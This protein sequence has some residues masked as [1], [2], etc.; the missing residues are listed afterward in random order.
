MPEIR[1]ANPSDLDGLVDLLGHLFA[2]EADFAPDPD[3][4]RWGLEAILAQ[5]NIGQIFVAEDHG[6]L[7]AMVSLLF[8]VSTAEGGRVAWLEDMVVTPT[9]RSS[10]IGSQLLRHAL[11]FARASDSRR[12]T[13]LTDSVNAAAQRFYARHG[14]AKSQMVAM[15]WRP[16]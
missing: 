12:V 7:V 16:S 4:Q 3:K 15:R 10:G 8:A 14:F 13:L 11:E 2:Q 1:P 5:P 9:H 6:A